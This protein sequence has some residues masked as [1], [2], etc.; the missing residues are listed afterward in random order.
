MP[1]CLNKLHHFL[2]KNIMFEVNVKK[3]CQKSGCKFIKAAFYKKKYCNNLRTSKERLLKSY[4]RFFFTYISNKYI[5]IKILWCSF[6]S[7]PILIKWRFFIFIQIFYLKHRSSFYKTHS[8]FTLE[9]SICNIISIKLNVIFL[10]CF[11]WE[12]FEK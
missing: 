5:F 8:T 9:T 4:E 11:L 1:N 3:W 2:L 10:Q 12:W 6:F 7:F